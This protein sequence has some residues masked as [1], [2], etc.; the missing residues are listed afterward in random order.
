MPDRP[1]AG[2]RLILVSWTFPSDFESGMN[3]S[4]K[5]SV[6]NPV[7]RDTT[8]SRYIYKLSVLFEVR[9]RL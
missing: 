1:S 2:I 3:D 8:T 5:Q 7:F 4:N 6:W 9:I